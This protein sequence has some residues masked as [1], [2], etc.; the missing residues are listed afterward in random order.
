MVELLLA[1][2]MPEYGHNVDTNNPILTVAPEDIVFCAHN[3]K[4]DRQMLIQSG[5]H[6]ALLPEHTICTWKCARHLYPDEAK[7]SNQSLRYS[8]GLDPLFLTIG[9]PHRALPDVAVTG[10]LLVHMLKEHTVEELVELTGK[11]VLLKRMTF[12]KYSGKLWEDVD[13]SYLRWL[14]GQDFGEDEKYTARYWLNVKEST[15]RA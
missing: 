10:A 15:R 1:R 2:G 12:G 13:V 14:L 3:A 11:P 6:P 7:Y 5:V 4:F 8:L 9:P